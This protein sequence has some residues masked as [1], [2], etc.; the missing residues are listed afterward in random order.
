M[1]I[2]VS[3]VKAE[4][5]GIYVSQKTVDRSKINIDGELLIKN[6]KA[7]KDAQSKI[8]EII[9]ELRLAYIDIQ[10]ENLL[11]NRDHELRRILDFLEVDGEFELTTYLTKINPDEL[12]EVITNYHEIVKILRGTEYADYLA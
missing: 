8:L 1:K 12:P 11:T 6:L 5:T 2:Y 9:Q 10:Y 4:Q 7:I 3:R